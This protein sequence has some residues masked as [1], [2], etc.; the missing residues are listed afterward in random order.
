MQIINSKVDN[1]ENYE[2]VIN[3]IKSLN[4]NSIFNVKESQ[5]IIDY[6]AKDGY[7]LY[8]FLIQKDKNFLW[9]LYLNEYSLAD[10]LKEF[11]A[12]LELNSVVTVI[13]SNEVFLKAVEF[14]ENF[15]IIALDT[16]TFPLKPIIDGVEQPKAVT[17]LSLLQLCVSEQSSFLDRENKR[18]FCFVVDLTANIN[19][20]FMKSILVSN[21]FVKVIHNAQYDVNI[22][23]SN[24]G[25]LLDNVWCT[26]VAERV[27]LN[28]EKGLKLANLAQRHLNIEM[29]KAMQHSEWH[30]RPLSEEQF[31]YSVLD[32]TILRD[33]YDS[34][35]YKKYENGWYT[36]KGKNKSFL[37]SEEVENKSILDFVSFNSDRTHV[38]WLKKFI[39]DGTARSFPLQDFSLNNIYYIPNVYEFAQ[40]LLGLVLNTQDMNKVFIYNNSYT[41]NNLL[42]D[43]H[44]FC[45]NFVQEESVI[46]CNLCFNN[47]Y[48]PSAENLCYT[49]CNN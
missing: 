49:C 31:V 5:L 6:P 20:E 42:V 19:M 9:N 11:D 47:I 15:N 8:R 45:E 37:I 38:D 44:A 25:I 39:I 4:K 35:V 36:K 13:N 33:L 40:D 43:F 24:K 32:S 10:K 1:L 48:K 28:S 2:K 46:K 23:Q 41:L 18:K 14:I 26:M 12:L 16:E 21:K 29:D 34:Q 30:I 27:N 17:T 3:K 22:I 7:I